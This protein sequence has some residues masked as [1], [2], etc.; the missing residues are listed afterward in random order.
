VSKIQI[1][2]ATFNRPTLILRSIDSALK[3]TFND[4]ELIVSDNST[5]NDTRDIISK[6]YNTNVIYTKRDKWL[7]GIEHLNIILSEI[8]S[9][10][11]IIFHDDDVMHPEM[12]NI[13][14]SKLVKN[15]DIL[16]VGCNAV[17][18][19]NNKNNKKSFSSLKIDKIIEKKSQLVEAYSINKSF[20]PFPSYLYKREIAEN[21]RFNMDHGGKFCDLAFLCEIL[22]YGKIY[23]IAKPL[24]TYFMHKN[25]DTAK[26]EFV[27]KI[28]LI[29]YL[30]KC[31]IE[32]KRFKAINILRAENIYAELKFSINNKINQNIQQKRFIKQSFIVYKYLG[33]K[34][35]SKMVF[36]Y[37]LHVKKLIHK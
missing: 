20:M 11:F 32:K 12:L 29:N 33:L 7:T 36:L 25:Q 31:L 18:N 28:K 2:I 27:D 23:F 26:H 13:L 4:F 6:N 24:M 8:K 3:Q 9:E 35:L 30:R 19:K 1:I 14:Y 16:A 34:M 22:N 21:I 15:N 17:V 5:N 10:Y 37:L